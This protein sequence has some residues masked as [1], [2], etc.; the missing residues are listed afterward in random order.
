MDIAA[1][2]RTA[3][4]AFQKIQTIASSFDVDESEDRKNAVKVGTVFIFALIGKVTAGK[5]PKDFSVEDWADLAG[6]VSDHVVEVDER[7]Y[8]IFVFRMYADFLN[9]SITSFKVKADDRVTDAVL[10]VSKE[11]K[12]LSNLMEN[13]ELSE[14]DYVDQCLWLSLEG[15]MKLIA[16]YAGSRVAG[17]EAGWLA[18]AVATLAVQYGKLRVYQMRDAKLDEFLAEQES[19]DV[20]NAAE[21]R[22]YKA[23]VK[24]EAD[25]FKILI[26]HAFDP[27]FREMLQGSAA[28]A[29]AAGADPKKVLRSEKDTDRFFTE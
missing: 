16:A 21:E 28:L 13:E 27:D 8:S 5:N 6:T 19:V 1:E 20:W 11:I 26:D 29:D 10:A 25:S 3:K 23:A 15:V 17:E 12:D 18:S 2:I 9:A 14:P 22:K 7:S 24:K 4:E